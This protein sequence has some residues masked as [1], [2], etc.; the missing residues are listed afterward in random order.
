[1]LVNVV[2]GPPGI[3]L[4]SVV[5]KLKVAGGIEAGE[6]DKGLVSP[7]EAALVDGGNVL[8]DDTVATGL[9]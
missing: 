1:V 4:V 5:G 9:G 3:E 7:L 8:L 6:G 2:I